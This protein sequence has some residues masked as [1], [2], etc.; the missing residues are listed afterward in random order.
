MPT[1]DRRTDTQWT[2]KIVE[3]ALISNIIYKVVGVLGINVKLRSA[4]IDRLGT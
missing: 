3:F 2:R 1:F 4:H